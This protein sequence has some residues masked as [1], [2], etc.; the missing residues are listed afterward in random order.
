MFFAD[1]L[2]KY[3]FVVMKRC[4]LLILMVLPLWVSG[5]GR[6]DA[7][8]SDS[9]YLSLLDEE[10][11]LKIR[12]DSMQAAIRTGRQALRSDTVNVAARSRDIL[13]TEEAL[14]ELRTRLGVLAAR[15]NA[16]EQEHL[17]NNLFSRPENPADSEGPAAARTAANL[18]DHPY[19]RENLSA[20]EYAWLRA[21]SGGEI[22]SLLISYRNISAE[23]HALA[24][25]YDMAAGQ[26]G[27][28]SLYRLFRRQTAEMRRL[29]S[30]FQARWGE[31]FGQEI[32]LYSYL[33]DRLNRTDDLA[34][35]NEKAREAGGV[36]AQGVMSAAF[37]AYPA[38]RALLADY[39][40][41]LARALSL[42]AAA[43]S[44]QQAGQAV[45]G[46]GLDIAP[47]EIVEREFIAYQ[48]ISFPERTP[49]TAEN[50][51]PA[52]TVPASG[53][54]YSVQV[55]TFSQRQPVSVFR[56]AA[57]VACERTANGQW[58]YFI[59]L[60]RSYGETEQAVAQLRE[61]GFRRPEPVRWQ[62]GV[63]EN[64]AAQVAETDGFYRIRI[65]S[66]TGELD[67]QARALLARYAPA[68]EITRAGGAIYIGTF[69]NRLHA[70][71]TAAA[72]RKISDLP[73]ETERIEE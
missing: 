7:L 6:V 2:K 65:E 50:P 71:D 42:T 43:D 13:R 62:D 55:G 28:D 68:K 35:L 34:A 52:L 45:E 31:R 51:I 14:F 58:R 49:Y 29:E 5:Q 8:R 64:L 46:A 44:L 69:T 11:E 70:D 10:T 16:I 23:L 37:A 4:L 66:P 18:V 3:I 40:S 26:G 57:P 24:A 59:G 32:Y 1:N 38:Q 67:P 48:D 60:L 39:Q 72:L 30:D 63:Y 22:D 17:M 54:V 25:A 20:E 33:L 36:S 9:V 73:V 12:E 47:V 15:I 19:L 56:G 53:T 21:A 61:A 41:A 27:A